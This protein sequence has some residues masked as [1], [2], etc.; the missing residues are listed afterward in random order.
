MPIPMTLKQKPIAEL[1]KEKTLEQLRAEK[2]IFTPEDA[3]P[4]MG[5]TAMHVRY[6][7]R[8]GKI[9]HVERGD[10]YFLYARTV[11]SVFKHVAPTAKKSR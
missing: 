9:E 6:L 3:A 8:N 11:Y 5:Y 2:Q 1:L 7:C 4:I 10:S